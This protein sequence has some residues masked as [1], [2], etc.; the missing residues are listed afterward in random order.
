[1][2]QLTSTRIGFKE[3]AQQSAKWNGDVVFLYRTMGHVLRLDQ[4]AL[5][6]KHA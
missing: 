4:S 6:R 1:V 2:F 3:R 5:F